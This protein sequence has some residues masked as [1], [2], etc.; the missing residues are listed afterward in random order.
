[1]KFTLK[2]YQA[3]AVDDAL[4]ALE[5]AK[6][7]YETEG[8]EVSVS[9][10]ATTGA[11]KTVMAAAVIEALFYG[12]STFDFEP[13]DGAVVIW[14]SDDPNL[15]DQTKFRLMEASEKLTHS[16]L[17]T[18]APPFAKPQLDPG[19]VYFLN[20]QRLGKNSLLTRG[21]VDGVDGQESFE[22]M[23][24]TAQPDMQ[25]W[26]IWETIANTITDPDLTV[27]LILDEAHRGFNTKATRDKPTLVRKLINGHAGYPPIPIVWGISA[28]I[29]R[30]KEAMEEAH[31]DKTRRQLPPV[32]VDGF[33]VQ[34]S[35]LVKDTILLDI[36]AEAGNF[37]TVLVRRGARKLRESSERWQQYAAGQGSAD[38]VQPLL[39]L[40]VPNKADHDQ[41]GVALN[42]IFREVGE[43][44]ADAVRHVFGDH[45][46]LRFGSWEVDWIEPQ[47][48]E[49][50]A[51]VRVLVAKD[52]ISTGWDCPRA[53]VMV[54]F[55][56]AKD[57]THIT[58]LLGRM[59]RSPLARRVPGDE[60][61]NA[62]ECLLP[63]FDRTMAGKVV[64]FL[65]GQI[66][67]ITAPV[68][69]TIIEECMLKPNPKLPESVWDSWD[70]MPTMTI[71]KRGSSPVRRLV[72]LALALSADG[73]RPGALRDATED[74]H[75]VLESQRRRHPKLLDKAVS[76][77]WAVRGQTIGGRTGSSH[78]S[79]EDFVERA[80]DRAI[81][82]G[83]TDAK[84]AFGA[85]IAQSYVN[86]LADQDEEDD[87]LREAYV[88]TSAL[89]IVPE[90]RA[91]IDKEA[92]SLSDKWFAR[93]RVQIRDLSDERRQVYDDIAALAT[94]PKVSELIRPRTRIEDYLEVQ[95]DGQYARARMVDRHLMS[96]EHG[97]C[98]ISSLNDWERKVVT[99]ELA[100]DNCVGWYRN[101]PRQAADSLGIAY[102]DELGNWRSM[103]PDFVFFNDVRGE[104]RPSIV[105]PHGH[106]LEDSLAKL[107]G[108]ARFAQ[109]HG[110]KFHRI[111]AVSSVGNVMR[112]LDLQNPLVRKA[113]L[114][115]Q[116]SP[117]EYYESDIAIDYV[118]DGHS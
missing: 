80:D 52:A 110:S 83:F 76:E 73:V 26:T 87:S 118:W 14:F 77:I 82:V 115:D 24:S 48:V 25:G 50:A 13:D 71:P 15:N 27:Y 33:R 105:D 38:V 5:R 6:G 34:E 67:E 7:I 54:S 96:D 8:K 114:H 106:H 59:V 112:I 95:P 117:M 65:T 40:Q 39:V 116:K 41:I 98:P 100:R 20:T 94:E 68:R 74:M 58:Q 23:T 72:T 111:D 22:S 9:L 53:E 84:R 88:T 104:V 36:P 63:F 85:D 42:E 92:D 29:D 64:K 11:G 86:F 90:V 101:P 55:R 57:H 46:P 32:T 21:H 60:K 49:D 28:T 1:M 12:N 17:V 18:I 37:D 16:D 103:H 43:L 66:D 61:L 79:Y 78:L 31:A 69:R 62:V 2:D 113:I 4:R 70:A 102:R 81:Q 10:S 51:K 97:M 107:Q 47:R 35:G 93:Y 45:A 91:Y 44:G 75:N 19:K 109:D 30:F 99:A 108:L 3:D 89:A 56:P